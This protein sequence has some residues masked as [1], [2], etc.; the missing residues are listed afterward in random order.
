MKV[1][2]KLFYYSLL[3]IT[4]RASVNMTHNSH[5]TKKLRCLQISN[6]IYFHCS[7]FLFVFIL[8]CSLLDEE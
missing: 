1:V 2:S 6:C 4:L 8:S 7:V 5:E 3:T